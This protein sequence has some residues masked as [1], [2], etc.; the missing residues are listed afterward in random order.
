MQRSRGTRIATTNARWAPCRDISIHVDL[1]FW[2]NFGR[3]V[4]RHYRRGWSLD[5]EFAL[6]P[7]A[8]PTNSVR[9]KLKRQ[10]AGVRFRS[11]AQHVASKA[12][13][14]WLHDRWPAGFNPGEF[15]DARPRAFGFDGPGN[16]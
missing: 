2:G 1:T 10:A 8:G 12:A 7:C 6:F 3:R 9:R 14:L 16:R 15:Q 4:F 5:G 13:S 11:A